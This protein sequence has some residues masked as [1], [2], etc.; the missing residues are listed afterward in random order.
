MDFSLKTSWHLVQT[1]EN[2]LL[3]KQQVMTQPAHR[4]ELLQPL[5][6]SQTLPTAFQNSPAHLFPDLST[7]LAYNR[8]LLHH[9]YQERIPLELHKNLSRHPLKLP[10]HQCSNVLKPKACNRQ[11]SVLTVGISILVKICYN[12]EPED[13][14]KQL[15]SY[16][17]PNYL[18][19]R[20]GARD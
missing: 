10:R 8:P 7:H 6:T 3:K 16:G 5:S 17:Q 9:P 12:N 15:V 13:R 14:S 4:L 11:N 2:L 18:F 20:G 1:R 19:T